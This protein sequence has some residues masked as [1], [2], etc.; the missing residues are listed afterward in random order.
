V[1]F[2]EPLA[3]R[4]ASQPERRELRAVAEDV[5]EVHHSPPA[6]RRQHGVV[7]RGAD[8]EVGALDRHMIDHFAIIAH[9][10]R[11][12]RCSAALTDVRTRR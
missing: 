11:A 10:G 3:R 9:P 4:L 7:E 5:T 2:S 1:R 12:C 8:V 6:E